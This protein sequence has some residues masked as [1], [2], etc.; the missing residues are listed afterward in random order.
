MADTGKVAYVSS[1]R[2]YKRTKDVPLDDV[3]AALETDK[4]RFRLLQPEGSSAPIAI[5]GHKAEM[6][7][8]HLL[9]WDAC[10]PHKNSSTCTS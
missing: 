7:R 1:G 5:V 3:A 9:L 10:P 2:L 6:I 8:F 4:G